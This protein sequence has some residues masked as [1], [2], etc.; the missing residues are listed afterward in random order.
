MK[1]CKMSYIFDPK[2]YFYNLCAKYV[3]IFA[4]Q[5][6]FWEAVKGH[7]RLKIVLTDVVFD[8][9]RDNYIFYLLKKSLIIL[10]YYFS[11]N[12]QKTMFFNNC[13]LVEPVDKPKFIKLV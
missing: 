11:S 12:Q 4:F 10:E 8:M 5:A 13:S 9:E 1:T 3:S 2:H 6:R 7:G